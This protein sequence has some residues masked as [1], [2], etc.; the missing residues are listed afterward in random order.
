MSNKRKRKRGSQGYRPTATRAIE[1]QPAPAATTT[2]ERRP[3]LFGGMFGT[4][5]PASLSSMPTYR[6]SL[7]RGFLLVGSNPILLAVPFLWTLITWVALVAFGYTGTPNVPLGQ[8]VSLPPLSIGA[9]LQSALVV[10][11]Q[12]AGIYA[13]LPMLFLRAILFATLAGLIAEGFRTGSVSVAGAVRGL[14]GVPIVLGGVILSLL[15]VMALFLVASSGPGFGSLAQVLLPAATVWL[16]GFLP[17]VAV[18]ERRSLPAALS[19]SVAGGRTPGGRQF[20]FCMLY[21]LLLT[22]VQAFTPG[23]RITAAPSLV[24][25]AYVLVVGY[26]H[27]GF[28]AAFGYRWLAIAGTVP[29][30]AAAA[31]RRRR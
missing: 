18:S 4:P 27:I 5:V 14:R 20:L 21:L 19:R 12:P 17:F 13:L 24:T 3:G 9:D 28:F 6:R 16:L 23:A 15:S 31:S 10:F 29:E 26:V 22:I 2:A 1:R 8:A 25:W 7:G 30:P 11:G